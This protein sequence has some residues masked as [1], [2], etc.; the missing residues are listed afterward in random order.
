V[1]G[2]KKRPAVLLLAALVCLAIAA[3]AF[4]GLILR[5]DSAGRIIFGSAWGALGV[6]WLARYLMG[7]SATE[8][9]E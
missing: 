5:S 9:E 6:I 8:P 2:T 1:S 3:V 7:Y 4:G